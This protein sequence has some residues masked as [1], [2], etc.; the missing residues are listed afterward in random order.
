VNES[1]QSGFLVLAPS[2]S[3]SAEVILDRLRA[4]RGE[5]E[6]I[7]LDLRQV[8]GLGLYLT[9]GYMLPASLWE[10]VGE[11]FGVDPE[12]RPLDPQVRLIID[13]DGIRSAGYLGYDDYWILSET[14][15]E[16]LES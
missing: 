11:T 1:T 14:L 7:V 2:S 10:Q 16:S 12:D 4:A 8:E 9:P 6:R 5:A 3:D 13:S 15:E